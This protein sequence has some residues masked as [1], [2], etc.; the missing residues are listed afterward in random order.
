MTY[1]L[2][3]VAGYFIKWCP[4]IWEITYQDIN[5]IWGGVKN[6]FKFWAFIHIEI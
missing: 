4:F 5:F 1:F 3:F 6:E 2:K